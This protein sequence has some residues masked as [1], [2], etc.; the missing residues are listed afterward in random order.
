MPISAALAA[1]LI[2]GGTSAGGSILS[3]ILGS[4]AAKDA[5][6]SQAA[7]AD[8]GANLA[9][10][11]AN[12]SLDFTKSEWNT[13]QNDIAPFLASGTGALSQLDTGMGITPTAPV[14]FGT[15]STNVAST[16]TSTTATAPASTGVSLASLIDPTP[17]SAFPQYAKTTAPTL[18]VG[19]N[20]T[21]TASFNQDFTSAAIDLASSANAGTISPA[22]YQTAMQN[23]IKQANMYAGP[24]QSGDAERTL[25]QVNGMLTGD[26]NNLDSYLAA[27]PVTANPNGS[28]TSGWVQDGALG[29]QPGTAGTG[30]SL[31]EYA[32]GQLTQPAATTPQ[33]PAATTPAPAITVP[34]ATTPAATAQTTNTSAPAPI[35]QEQTQ[36][37][38]PTSAQ[39]IGTAGN[40]TPASLNEAWNTPFVAPTA[41]EAAATPG[42]QFQLQQGEQA[43]QR[44]AAAQG[45]LLTGGTLKDLNDYAQGVAST[46]YQT[47]YNNALNQYQQAYNIFNNNQNNQFNRL[48][49]MSG[50]GQTA[51]SQLGTYGSNTANNVSNTELTSAN[52]VGNQLNNSAAA[53]ASGYVGG[54][55]ALT[56]GINAGAQT[57]SQMLL[58]LSGQKNNQNLSSNTGSMQFGA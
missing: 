31:A 5:A 17:I 34:A 43:L 2:A 22:Q 15:P 39:T 35:Q 18:S 3:G 50:T 52:Q 51:N 26:E 36:T 32:L 13:L 27:H 38:Q 47:A 1:T 21:Q 12:N 53:T 41:A 37:S 30:Q 25:S 10:Q 23:L 19:L 49:A 46:N 56:S 33:T 6:N 58:A 45:N 4:N 28:L 54:T 24:G 14:N 42:Y 57:L 20:N 29:W 9:S 48:S 40:L 16:P 7:A 44:S 55:N 8:Y 11:N